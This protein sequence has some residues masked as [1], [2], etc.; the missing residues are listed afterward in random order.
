LI[1]EEGLT[2][3]TGFAVLRPRKSEYAEIVYLAG[4]AQE[5]D[6]TITNNAQ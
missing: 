5:A 3:S 4:T 2:A 1:A 6:S